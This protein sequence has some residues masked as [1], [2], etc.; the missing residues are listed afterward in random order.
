MQP[1]LIVC[2]KYL[3]VG[4][5][6]PGKEYEGTR[7]N[8]GFMVLDRFLNRLNEEKNTEYS[9]SVDRHAYVSEVRIKGRTL[10]LVKPTTFMNLSGKAVKYW[11]DREKIPVEN[12][13]VIVDDLALELGTIRLRMSGSDG[14]HNGL[15][16]IINILGHNKF[17]RLRF[18]I[19]NN[20]ARGHQI[21]FVLGKIT[22]ED[23]DIV[24]RKLDMCSDIIVSFSTIGMDRTMNAFNGK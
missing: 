16:D 20:F 1:F 12:M 7:H 2:M 5:G 4:L 17:N 24:D 11:L 19:G 6:N 3:I 10:V 23:K 9:F 18:G 14:G 8:I 22:G 21:D 15:K 13:L